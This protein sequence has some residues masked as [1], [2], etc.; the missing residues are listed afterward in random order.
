MLEDADLDAAV[1]EGV[2]T[3]DSADALR[4]F[5]AGRPRD[6]L[7]EKPDDEHFRFLRGFNDFFFAIGVLFLGFG[8]VHFA[9]T[10]TAAN[11]AGA[12][13]LWALAEL[14]IRR[15]R[16]VLPGIVLAC[17]FALLFLQAVPADLWLFPGYRPTTAIHY[18]QRS[19]LGEIFGNFFGAYAPVVIATKALVACA[20]TIAFYAR[21][22]LPFTLLLVAGSL[23]IAVSSIASLRAPDISFASDKQFYASIFLVCGVAVFGAAMA[24]DL[25]DRDRRTRRADCAFWLH[26]LAAP[27]IVNSLIGFVTLDATNITS[28]VAI[29]IVSIVTALTLVAIV[30]DR[31]ALLVSALS[32]IGIVIA[33][34][35]RSAAAT[36]NVTVFFV[37]L[38]ILG[39]VVLTLGV[40]W[41]P[42]RRLFVATLPAA[43]AGRL[44]PVVPA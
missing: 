15:M 3:Q 9:G 8:F 12:A 2:L 16:L 34:A 24:F 31:R 38:V 7:D 41:F 42:L 26:L 32:Y 29:T 10:Q 23:V 1:A 27:L 37:T 25:S 28:A 30:V 35:I 39:S 4:V 21:F 17:F 36:D 6:A 14:L 22:R 11:L 20:A 44:P 33:G 5:A 18:A 19:T 40:G 13:I 43:L